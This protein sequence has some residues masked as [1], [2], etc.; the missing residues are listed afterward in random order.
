MRLLDA[1][2]SSGGLIRDEW[3]RQQGFA[4]LRF[5]NNDVLK[6]TDA[7]LETI[8]ARLNEFEA[9]PGALR[10]P[11]SPLRGEGKPASR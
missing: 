8:M 2:E 1:D 6:H 10:A 9:S 11:R 7:V 3:L 5:W 4:V